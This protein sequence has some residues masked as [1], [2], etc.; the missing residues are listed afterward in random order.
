MRERLFIVNCHNI[1]DIVFL[2]IPNIHKG[3]GKLKQMSYVFKLICNHCYLSFKLKLHPDNFAKREMLSHGVFC[4][5]R[6]QH[7]CPWKGP[8]GSLEVCILL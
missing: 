3:V 6:K 4:Q 7:G 8:L 5:L 1:Y 2:V